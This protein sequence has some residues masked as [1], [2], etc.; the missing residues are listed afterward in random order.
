VLVNDRW[1][2]IDPNLMLDENRL[3]KDEQNYLHQVTPH[4]IW[5]YIFTFVVLI[6]AAAPLRY[7]F[8][9]WDS[10]KLL[11]I[12][13]PILSLYWWLQFRIMRSAA[14][15]AQHDAQIE[16]TNTFAPQ[17]LT[18]FIKLRTVIQH[19]SPFI[20]LTS[21][22]LLGLSVALAGF[23]LFGQQQRAN[24]Q[25]RGILQYV[26]V[27]STGYLWRSNYPISSLQQRYFSGIMGVMLVSL[28]FSN[29]MLSASIGLWAGQLRR[30]AKFRLILAVGVFGVFLG[31]Y[32]L[33]MMPPWACIRSRMLTGNCDECA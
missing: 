8:G 28:T 20:L 27:V 6:V 19:H 17:E 21:I 24:P 15:L 26:G 1:L 29:S 2:F 23:L 33:R 3:I 7:S 10:A 5:H 14:Y 4:R 18:M 12:A 32:L 11:A 22:A 30:A 9:L 31:L 25:E 13:L 16:G